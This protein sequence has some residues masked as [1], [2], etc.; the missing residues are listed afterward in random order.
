MFVNI[1]GCKNPKDA[2]A[3]YFRQLKKT[4]GSDVAMQIAKDEEISRDD[5]Y[6]QAKI[7]ANAINTYCDPKTKVSDKNPFCCVATNIGMENIP[8]L[9]CRACSGEKNRLCNMIHNQKS[10]D[11]DGKILQYCKWANG[12]CGG[13]GTDKNLMVDSDACDGRNSYC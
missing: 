8:S 1:P 6:A 3:N 12:K 10:C 2:A 11:G 5:N 7:A 4:L 13:D 9:S